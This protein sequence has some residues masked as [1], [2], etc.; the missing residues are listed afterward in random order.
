[1]RFFVPSELRVLPWAGLNCPFG[2]F[3]V[4]YIIRKPFLPDYITSQTIQV[5]MEL[6]FVAD[7]YKSALL[8]ALPRGIDLIEELFLAHQTLILCALE[9]VENG[10]NEVAKAAIAGLGFSL[11]PFQ[12]GFIDPDGGPLF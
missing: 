12:Q 6:L 5:L 7:F 3:Q 9:F 2:A 4:H 8:D 10:F 11:H 1:M